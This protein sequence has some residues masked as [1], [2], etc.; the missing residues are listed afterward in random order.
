MTSPPTAAASSLLESDAVSSDSSL[1]SAT[2]AAPTSASAVFTSCDV[3]QL[4][5]LQAEFVRER[6]WDQFHTPRNV[7]LA[8]VGEV[9]ELAEIFQWRGEVSVGCMELSSEER[10]HLSDELADCLLYLL[11]LSDICNVDLTVAAINKLKANAMKYPIERCKGS[12]A[13]YTA[14]K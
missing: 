6:D 1:S 7:L 11:R 13:K 4:R 8:L 3:E 9:G 2:A 14:Y 5:R 12:A 10:K